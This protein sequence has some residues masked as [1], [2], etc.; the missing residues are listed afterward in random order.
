VYYVYQRRIEAYDKKFYLSEIQLNNFCHVTGRNLEH[1]AYC[2][3]LAPRGYH[4]LPAPMARLG[5]HKFSSDNEVK[6]ALIR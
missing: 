6:T 5:S 3:D 1:P 4:L 2:P